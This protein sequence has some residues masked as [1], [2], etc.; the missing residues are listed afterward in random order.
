MSR[1]AW[2]WVV[3]LAVADLVVIA[4]T[5]H[6]HVRF[7]HTP[8]GPEVMPAGQLLGWALSGALLIILVCVIIG[9]RNEAKYRTT[10]MPKSLDGTADHDGD[11]P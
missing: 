8:N 5:V 4:L 3:T 2:R 11:P 9:A 6:A 1:R 7:H 10:P